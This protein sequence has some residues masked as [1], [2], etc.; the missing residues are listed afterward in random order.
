MIQL[1]KLFRTSC[2]WVLLIAALGVSCDKSSEDPTP[3]KPKVPPTN[4]A[5]DPTT[6]HQ[7]IAG[8]GG[9]NQMWGTQFP[10]ATDM[11]KAFGTGSDELGLSIFRVR[12]ASNPDEWP[13]ITSVAKEAAKHN[14][15]ILASPWSPP[16][17]LKSNGSDIRG[18]LL[19]EKYDDYVD[20][21]NAFIDLMKS[22]GVDLY[23]ISIQNEPDWPATY[24]SCDWTAPEMTNFLANHGGNIDA[25]VKVAAPESLNFSQTFTNALLNDENA[26]NNFDIAAGHLYGGGLAPFPL[27]K[28]KGKEIWM[29]EYLMNQNATSSWSTLAPSVIWNESI[30]MLESVHGAMI[31]DWNAYI[32]WYLKRYYSFLGDGDQGTTSGVILKRGYAFSHFSKFVRPGY[33]RVGA[34][35]SKTD[36]LVTAYQGD[37][38]TVIVL[39][40]SGT[41]TA[42]NISIK[43]GDVVPS[44]ATAYTTSLESNRTVL[45]ITPNEDGLLLLEL[46]GKSVTTV[47]IQN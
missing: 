5:I 43:V 7:T 6:T 20:H 14:A 45:D 1:S 22:N 37:G 13:L 39:I 24:E 17:S 26:S 28:Q 36:V 31:N 42:S 25:S 16:P 29:T 21:I 41:S 47:V 33:V 18:Y 30:A 9:A 2:T 44:A 10:N 27:A 15:K 8:F 32:W 4:L 38:K 46:K 12:I 11:Q 34:T 40:N 19:E 23:A 35:L 3:P